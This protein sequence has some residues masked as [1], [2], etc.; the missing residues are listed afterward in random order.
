[1]TFNVITP[2]QVK[3]LKTLD[4]PIVPIVGND[5][6]AYRIMERFANAA[7]K[8]GWVK[9]DIELVIDEMRS[10]DYN[11]LLVVAIKFTCESEKDNG[12]SITVTPMINL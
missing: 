3:H 6:D 11:H 4:K 10:A 1:M 7:E 5:Y 9:E 8:A 2:K 12:Y